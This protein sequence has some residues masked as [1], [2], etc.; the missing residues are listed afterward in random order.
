MELKLEQRL[1]YL[2]SNN[3]STRQHHL[4]RMLHVVQAAERCD[5]AR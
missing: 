2:L 5:S 3:N 1:T 4:F